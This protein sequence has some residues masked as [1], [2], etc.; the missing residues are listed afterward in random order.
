MN[1]EW[2]KQSIENQLQDDTIT[3]KNHNE[4]KNSEHIKYALM[5]S[6]HENCPLTKKK[7]NRNSPG[8]I[9]RRKSG[10]CD[11]YRSAFTNY[12]KLIR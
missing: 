5:T 9:M 11:N 10:E 8:G 2:F 4:I 6:Y 1:K 7:Y 12:N 3:I